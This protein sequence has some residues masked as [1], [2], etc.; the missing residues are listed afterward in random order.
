LQASISAKNSAAYYVFFFVPLLASS[1]TVSR[2][3]DIA[4]RANNE[5]RN[6]KDDMPV[7]VADTHRVL[8][9]RCLKSR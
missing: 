6:T 8:K 4:P 3:S 9:I 5:I 7:R 2:A 1:W